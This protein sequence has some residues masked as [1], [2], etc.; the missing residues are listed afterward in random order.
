MKQLVLVTGGTGYIG[1]RLVPR[2]L[3]A[4]F[5]VRC[6]A[7]DPARLQK[8][9]W[10]GQVELVE[11]DVLRRET[12]AAAMQNVSVAYYFVHSL[13]AGSNFLEQD[14]LAARNFG[15][16]A[17]RANVAR[18]IY[19]GGLGDTSTAL[20]AHLR[21]RHETGDAL[22]ESGVPVTEFRAGVIVGSGSISF[23][24]IRYLT[25]RVPLM[26]CPRWVFTRIQPIAIRNVLDYLIAALRVPESTGRIIE[27]G[28]AD[29]ITYGKMLTFYAEVRGL[30]RWLVPVPV[31]TPKL[32]S[33][34]VQLVT[35]IPASIAR[36]L[37]AGLR[38]E[39]IVRDDLARR[40]FPSIQP[41]DYR[42]AVKLALEKLEAREVETAEIDSPATSQRDA[43]PVV[44]L[45]THE[46]MIIERR[47]I[48]VDASAEAIFRAFT[49]L[50]GARG[51]LYM[52]WAWRIR[53]AFDRLF[54]G[55]GLR[56]GRRDPQFLC[57][58][59]ALDF[60]RVE[61]I[62]P[63]RMLRLRA[64]MKLPGKAW[65]QFEVKTQDHYP[66]PL[67]AQTAFFAPKGLLGLIYWYGLYPVH[68]LIFRGMIQKLSDLATRESQTTVLDERGADSFKF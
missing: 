67:L 19:L 31:L 58:G 22:R 36:P 39:I 8:R 62:D 60:W 42:V 10:S 33:Y 59:E 45:A 20:S 46:G 63:G 57:V 18:I 55:V 41:L 7:R 24:M 50:G 1:G 23:E 47:Q 29:V 9:P 15:A 17:K 35:P 51:W 26:I 28:G 14:V 49:G 11:G 6:L 56:P 16:S 34:W 61:A 5:R 43:T 65:L 38:N 48:A 37:V 44:A 32:S 54:G 25:E 12:L 2:L 13:G 21:S 4:G 30:R 40:L 27:I 52:N 64:E 66:R 3:E 68:A 53:G